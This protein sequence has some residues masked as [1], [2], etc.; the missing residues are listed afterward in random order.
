MF[1]VEECWAKAAE[2]RALAVSDPGHRLKH[3]NAAEAWM[4]LASK[5]EHPKD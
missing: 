4:V 2:K 5:L 1:S 3:L